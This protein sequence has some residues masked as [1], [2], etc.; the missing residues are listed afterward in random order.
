VV[1][2]LAWAGMVWQ[3][4]R[5][6]ETELA[7]EKAFLSIPVGCFDMGSPD[8][9]DGRFTNEG[10]VHNV[11]PKAFEL[12]K[13]EVTQVQWRRVMVF[14]NPEPSFFKGDERRPIEQVSWNEV[15]F[16]VRLMSFFGGHHYRLPSEAEWE[17][18]ARAGTTMARY[19]GGRAEDGCPYE[20]ITDLSFKKSNPDGAL[21]VTNLVVQCDDSH[22]ETAPVG[23][24][25][26]NSFGLYDM[27][28][29]VAE[30]VEDCYVNNYAAAPKDGSAV[31]A[32]DCAKRVVRSGSWGHIPRLARAAYRN[33]FAPDYRD[34]NFGFRLARTITP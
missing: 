20:N 5:A 12:G 3:G 17:Y 29:N 8:D 28:G 2:G 32:P 23:S 26:P 34:Y 13:F 4:V 10:P 22:D 30:W 15:Q 14:I 6:V 25:K 27:L 11:C 1:G 33:G 31:T 24:L 19:W 21:S 9:E 18:A 7:S 16:F